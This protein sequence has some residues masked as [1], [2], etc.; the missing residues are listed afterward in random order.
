[1]KTGL[2]AIVAASFLFGACS[3]KDTKNKNVPIVPIVQPV[4]YQTRLKCSNIIKKEIQGTAFYACSEDYSP[5]VQEVFE[6]IGDVKSYGKET[7][8]FDDSIN[9][10]DYRDGNPAQV[11]TLFMLGVAPKF[12]VSVDCR[13]LFLV[14]NSYR[15]LIEE[16]TIFRSLSDNLL[17]EKEFYENSGFDTGRRACMDFSP[18]GS[19]NPDFMGYPPEEK[20]FAVLHEDW[21]YYSL[22]NSE[23]LFGPESSVDEPVATVMGFA[24]AMDYLQAHYGADSELYKAEAALFEKW[25]VYSNLVNNSYIE[26]SELYSRDISDA[27]KER[28]KQEILAKSK[29][30]GFKMNNA[31]IMLQSPYTELFLIAYD[32]YTAH[33]NI[34]ELA[35][36]MSMVPAT[37]EEARVYL[38]LQAYS[39]Y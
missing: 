37:K 33:P 13:V 20:I 16:P 39:D 2:A 4:A 3:G 15:T 6:L 8:G 23:Q 25:R 9:Y 35:E 11:N 19:I 26:L 10:R 12:Q 7:L 38:Q 32:V 34:K 30:A 1:M 28:L 5:E 24:S 21:H 29:E 14:D 22:L 27:E 36:I 31:V 17:D 18:G